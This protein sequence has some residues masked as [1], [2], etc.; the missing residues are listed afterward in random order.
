[1]STDVRAETQAQPEPF[2]ENI[3]STLFTDNR[4]TVRIDSASL[5]GSVLTAAG[6]VKYSG[7]TVHANISDEADVAGTSGSSAF[8]MQ[9]EMDGETS[10]LRWS[11]RTCA[12]ADSS[13]FAVTST[14]G[15]EDVWI[16]GSTTG[17][18]D[19]QG[20]VTDAGMALMRYNSSGDQLMLERR[21]NAGEKYEWIGVVDNG[22]SEKME[23]G[24]L[25][26]SSKQRFE[27]LEEVLFAQVV[28]ETGSTV[29]QTLVTEEE[30]A[31]NEVF[32]S[33][34]SFGKNLY[35]VGRR[36]LQVN[37]T[38][39][40]EPTI[41]KI[42]LKEMKVVGISKMEYELQRTAGVCA[43]SGNVTTSYV[44]RTNNQGRLIVQS[45]D[46]EMK[47]K[48]GTEVRIQ[49]DID[50]PKAIKSSV[51]GCDA[52][53]PVP[54]ILMNTAEALNLSAP[55]W[56]VKRRLTNVR[57]AVVAVESG[58]FIG[59]SQSQRSTEWVAA[60]LIGSNPWIVY[61]KEGYK[62]LLT[63][64][65]M[66]TREK[67]TN[68]PQPTASATPV[69]ECIGEGTIL[70][71]QTVVEHVVQDDRMRMQLHPLVRRVRRK[72]LCRTAE[73]DVICATAKH[74]VRADGRMMFMEELCEMHGDCYES[75][76]H[77]MNFKAECGVM[78]PAAA[79]GVQL[80]MHAA[81]GDE[82]LGEAIRVVERE[83]AQRHG[84]I[85]MHAWWWLRTL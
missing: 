36:K 72:V 85:L 84:G 38:T 62:P 78:L 29:R 60:G 35:V 33:A 19:G 4:V 73:A 24:L 76:Q 43:E 11:K 64:V 57:P 1:M 75:L 65:A 17:L 12:C 55:D 14:N 37:W 53:K 9:M 46:S 66:R 23:V 8:V 45:M 39:N 79:D 77:V 71:G 7:I 13:R 63:R 32:W 47:K 40:F 67:E 82:A 16:A 18:P 54:A 83:C 44:A 41:T 20:G 25:A 10:T 50:Y 81:V 30:N 59:I 69:A 27:G 31:V 68:T 48:N 34:D 6:V 22:E 15:G 58:D 61:G 5:S 70:G 3:L 51:A 21:G 52:S 2:S 26:T 80:S 74:V 56:D 49:R 28:N 42:D